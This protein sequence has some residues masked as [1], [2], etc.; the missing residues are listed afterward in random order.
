MSRNAIGHRDNGKVPKDS[1][2]VLDETRRHRG[3]SRT[4]YKCPSL[5]LSPWKFSQYYNYDAPKSRWRRQGT[6]VTSQIKEGILIAA[7]SPTV[8]LW[9]IRCNADLHCVRKSFVFQLPQHQ[10]N[11][12]SAHVD[13]PCSHTVHA[14][15]SPPV[16]LIA[17]CPVD[18]KL[19]S[20]LVI[21][22]S[23]IK[24]Q[25]VYS[26]SDGSDSSLTVMM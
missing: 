9:C 21:I 5:D 20:E 17:C 1:V 4:N 16:H 12:A 23:S 24:P 15:A 6:L 2:V 10:W 26:D 8:Y 11:A 13:Y 3:S 19:L 25:P 7:L 22:K 18:N 14:W